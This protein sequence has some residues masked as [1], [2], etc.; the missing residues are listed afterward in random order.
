MKGV[1]SVSESVREALCEGK[2]FGFRRKHNVEAC[3]AVEGQPFEQRPSRQL[4]RLAGRGKPRL[5][6]RLPTWIRHEDP[7]RAFGEEHLYGWHQHQTPRALTPRP[8]SALPSR[9]RLVPCHYR[10]IA[11]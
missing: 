3:V 11:R 6:D 2:P 1:V 4:V 9:P 10:T 7:G 5:Q 8:S